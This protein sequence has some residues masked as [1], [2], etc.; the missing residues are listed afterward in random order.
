M[1]DISHG[2]HFFMSNFD[3]FGEVI[4]SPKKTIDALPRPINDWAYNLYI[5]L[6]SKKGLTAFDAAGTYGS[7]KF[8]ERINE[9][10]NTF[11]GLLA[12]EKVE[13]R[14][15]IKGKVRCTKYSISNTQL[16]FDVYFK[17]N[18]KGGSKILK[19]TNND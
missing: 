4:P 2:N 14:K 15:R 3:L 5:L 19:R 7:I 18:T 11:D 13:V 6:D 17:V 16:A 12:K 1:T 9:V 10:G 8:Q